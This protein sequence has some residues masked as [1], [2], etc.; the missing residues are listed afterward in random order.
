MGLVGF[1]AAREVKGDCIKERALLRST[2]RQGC[3]GA[4]RL[5][6]AALSCCV[7]AVAAQAQTPPP[8]G[9]TAGQRHA[10]PSKADHGEAQKQRRSRP[11]NLI[12]HGGP[13]KAIAVDDASERALTG[14][15]DYA[16]MSWDIT[17]EAPQR[18]YRFDDHNGAV[19]AVAFVPGGKLALAAGDDGAVA[20]WDLSSHK[21]VHRFQGHQAKIVGLAVT[22]DGRWA[23]SA[24]WDR[25]ARIWDLTKLAAGPVLKGHTGPVNAVVFSGD[26]MRVY[27]AS[28]DGSIGLWNKEDGSF[29]RPLHRHGWGIN[30]LARL[31]GTEQLVFGAL[32]GAA[33]IIDGETGEVIRELPAHE[34]PVLSLAVLEKPGLIATG[35]GGGVIRVLRSGD[36]SMIQE[37]RNPYG[38]VWALAFVGHGTALYYGGLDDFA[39]FWRIAPRDPFEAIDSPFPRRFQVRAK[40]GDTQLATGELQFARKCSVCHTV[41]VD[42]GNRAGPSLHKVFGRRIGTLAGYP[43][44]DALRKLDIV[45]TEETI[46][47]LF[48]LGPETFT[49][50]S[51]MPLQKMTNPAQRQALIAYLKRATEPGQPGLDEDENATR[52]QPSDRREKQ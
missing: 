9:E 12:G 25:T 39:T 18:L 42:G 43:Y 38:P 49:P 7:V 17:R 27:T 20:L 52:A 26:G 47:K 28:A 46:G 13:I 21:L 37:Y 23:A 24:G 48:E 33:A 40:G 32:N 15:F 8:S 29:R 51:K 11:G 45:W 4:L 35:G 5:L 31:P 16:M 34:R 41:Q 22:A 1:V 50:G 44:S 14:S 6:A 19:N 2:R 3:R 36:G 10:G 30:V